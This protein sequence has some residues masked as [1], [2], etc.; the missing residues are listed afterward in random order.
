MAWSY[1]SAVRS[2]GGSFFAAAPRD[3]DLDNHRGSAAMGTGYLDRSAERLDAILESCEPRASARIC[4][5]GP[6]VADLDPQYPLPRFGSDLGAV[7][8]GILDR[9]RERLTHHEVRG[10]LD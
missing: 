10:R 9:V 4:P 6:V 5:S 1:I 3:R 2:I 7:G 8:F